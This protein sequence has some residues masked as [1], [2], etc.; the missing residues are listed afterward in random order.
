MPGRG[1]IGIFFRSWY[2]DP[3]VERVEGFDA[4]KDWSRA[5]LETN[6]FEEQL[7]ERGIVLCKFWIHISPEEQLR[8]FKERETVAYK[9]YKI[10][11][12]DWRNRKKW[13]DYRLAVNDMVTRCSTEYAP[14]TLVAGNDKKSARVQ[15]PPDHRRSARKRALSPDL[16]PRDRTA[17]SRR[18]VSSGSARPCTGRSPSPRGSRPASS[19]ASSA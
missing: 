3:L 8:R 16:D 14:W 12:E 7:T 2:S 17:P 15:I 18:P 19:S 5:Y 11:D 6:E 9:R 13:D 1:C 4:E 10:T